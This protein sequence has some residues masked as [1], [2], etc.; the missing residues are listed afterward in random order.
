MMGRSIIKLFATSV[1]ASS[2]SLLLSTPVG[3]ASNS[4][5]WSQ[6]T[7]SLYTEKYGHIH[8][9]HGL[10]LGSGTNALRAVVANASQYYT[11]YSSTGNPVGYTYIG[12]LY[13]SGDATVLQRVEVRTGLNQ[14]ISTAFPTKVGSNPLPNIKYGN[15]TQFAWWVNDNHWSTVIKNQLHQ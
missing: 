13:Y 15:K 1:V 7:P 3:A 14:T 4:L 5:I 2:A 10:D 11:R 8:S 9:V 12:T 6:A